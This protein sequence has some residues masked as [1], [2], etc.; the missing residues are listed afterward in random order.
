M[1]LIFVCLC[2]AATQIAFGQQVIDVSKENVN[3]GSNMFYSVGGAPFVN[4]K[5]VSLVEGTPYFKKDWM[6]A[7]VIM[8]L[9]KEYKDVDVKINLFDQQIHYKGEKEVELVATSPIKAVILSDPLNG[10]AYHFIHSSFIPVTAEQPKK[11][12]YQLLD[13]GKASLYKSF[14]KEISE[15]MPYGSAT[16]E[17]K[18]STRET[19]LIHYNNV[20]LEI[21]KIKDS[22]KI[23]AN[24][25]KEL[26]EF[27]SKKEDKK[28]SMDERFKALIKYYNSLL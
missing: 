6:S 27:L 17:Q 3:I 20:F 14:T 23:L 7:T 25:E 5:F 13:S 2:L 4:A 28:Q 10:N 1:R 22:P 15:S 19:Y 12:W 11:G 24:K 26:E 9:G 8:P 16:V 18:M 21:K